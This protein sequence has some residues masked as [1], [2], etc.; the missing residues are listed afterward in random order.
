MLDLHDLGGLDLGDGVALFQSAIWRT[1]IF[2]PPI[3]AICHIGNLCRHHG[4][5]GIIASIL[6]VYSF[7]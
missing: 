4:A 1:E 7:T 2:T 5:P 3:A 6:V